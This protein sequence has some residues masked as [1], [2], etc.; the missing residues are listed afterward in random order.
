MQ[1]HAWYWF[2]HFTREDSQ[3]Q[4]ITMNSAACQCRAANDRECLF[5]VITNFSG[6]VTYCLFST[7]E[8]RGVALMKFQAL[9][10]GSKKMVIHH[11][12]KDEGVVDKSFRIDI[13]GIQ[14]TIFS[15]IPRMFFKTVRQL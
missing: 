10:A 6:E 15:T 1:S 3:I 4:L 12:V 11:L 13:D 9:P 7:R 8:I 14:G 2:C 5:D